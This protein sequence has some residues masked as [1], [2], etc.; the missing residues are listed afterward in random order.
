MQIR[1]TRLVVTEMDEQ[2]ALNAEFEYWLSRE[3]ITLP[4]ER[5][6]DAFA[7]F[8][9]VRKHVGIVDTASRSNPDPSTVFVLRPGTVPS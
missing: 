6:A 2:D 3:G 5:R 9:D 7:D 4:A 8:A 1:I